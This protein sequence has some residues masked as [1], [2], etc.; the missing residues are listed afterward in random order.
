[1]LALARAGRIRSGRAPTGPVR[2]RMP[3]GGG[4]PEAPSARRAVRWRACVATGTC[5]HRRLGTAT[6]RQLPGPAVERRP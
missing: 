5:R 3:A 1:M 4:V 6:G 2:C